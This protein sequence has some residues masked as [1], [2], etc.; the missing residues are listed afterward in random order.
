MIRGEQFT[1]PFTLAFQDA[2]CCRVECSI[3]IDVAI[4]GRN[5]KL[6]MRVRGASD[7]LLVE[8]NR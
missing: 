7:Y 4:F 8:L 1:K 2:F 3:A 5:Y 6:A